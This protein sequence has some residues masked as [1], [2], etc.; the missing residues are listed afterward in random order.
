MGGVYEG[1]WSASTIEGEGVDAIRERPSFS[2][3]YREARP[4]AVGVALLLTRDRHRAEDLVQD[5]FA[6][7]HG[8][9]DTVDNPEAFLRTSVVHACRNEHRRATREK[10][11]LRRAEE[12]A[13]VLDPDVFELV[14]AVARLPYRQRAVIVLR[15]YAD[16]SE[17]DIAAALGCAPGTVKSLA[18]RALQTLQQEV[19]R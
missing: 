6:R 2:E 14:D 13:R 15:Y 5:V 10:A 7:L 12:R 4:W 19:P 1:V 8:R 17:K 16:L 11:R 9:Y 18:S 3:F